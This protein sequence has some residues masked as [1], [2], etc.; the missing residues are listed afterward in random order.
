LP[1]AV[2]SE[3]ALCALVDAI[4]GFLVAVSSNA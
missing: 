4:D 3:E 2:A 1:L